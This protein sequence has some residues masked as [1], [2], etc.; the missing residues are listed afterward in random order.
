MA[1]FVRTMGKT[2]PFSAVCR[3]A[4]PRKPPPAI[5]ALAAPRAMRKLPA[6]SSASTSVPPIFMSMG[7][8]TVDGVA[9]AG[10]AE[11]LMG[12]VSG[13]GMGVGAGA[14]GGVLY[15]LWL[16]FPKRAL[17]QGSV[18]LVVGMIVSIQ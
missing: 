9:D 4:I 2:L 8:T 12:T 18:V 13:V 6:K 14:A 15:M 3:E 16:T 10:C 17:S 1:V 5:N 11:T 7:L